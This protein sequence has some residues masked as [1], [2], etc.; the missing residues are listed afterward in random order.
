M[1]SRLNPDL[2]GLTGRQKLF[3]D[4]GSGILSGGLAGMAVCPSKFSLV[5]DAWKCLLIEN[6]IM[7]VSSGLLFF[8]W[9]L[10]RP[11]FRLPRTEAPAETLSGLSARYV[12]ALINNLLGSLPLRKR[13]FHWVDLARFTQGWDSEDATLALG[14]HCWG[15]SLRTLLPLLRGS[16]QQRCSVS[17]AHSWPRFVWIVM[18]LVSWCLIIMLRLAL[19]FCFLLQ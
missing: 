18:A 15:H 14:Q 10:Q 9:M 17:S 4:V 5:I 12:D 16:S 6:W 7:L 2:S 19:P 3:M 1:R 8:L 13:F 11:W